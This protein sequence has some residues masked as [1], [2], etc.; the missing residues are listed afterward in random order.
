M[1]FIAAN[2]IAT[3]LAKPNDGFNDIVTSRI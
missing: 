3:P 2:K 1:P